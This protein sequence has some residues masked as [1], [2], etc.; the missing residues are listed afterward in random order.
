MRDELI[1]RQQAVEALFDWEMTYDWDD[2]C[3][4]ENP[5]PTYIVSPSDV[6]EHLPSAEPEPLTDKEQRIFLAAMGRELKVCK[7]VDDELIREPYEDSLVYI[8]KEI[9]RKV[10]AVL[11]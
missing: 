2:H 1:S 9:E 6:I 10:K 3:R 4:E 8:C 5:K 11:W 7:E